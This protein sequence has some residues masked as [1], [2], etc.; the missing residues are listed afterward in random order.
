MT[1]LDEQMRMMP[2]VAYAFSRSH[3]NAVAMHFF[4]NPGYTDWGAAVG[5]ARYG[6]YH[7]S[8]ISDMLEDG[9]ILDAKTGQGYS[10]STTA[11]SG[12]QKVQAGYEAFCR[13]YAGS[14]MIQQMGKPDW[15]AYAVGDMG[16]NAMAAC[17]SQKDGTRI[18]AW[19]KGY[20][21]LVDAGLMTGPDLE[22]AVMDNLA[23]YGHVFGNP[24][25]DPTV[26]KAAA[27]Y[28]AMRHEAGHYHHFNNIF[29]RPVDAEEYQTYM[30][31]AQFYRQLAEE[32]KDSNYAMSKFYGAIADVSEAKASMY[33]RDSQYCHDKAS[34]DQQSGLEAA[35][36]LDCDATEGSAQDAESSD[37]AGDG[38]DASG[39]GAGDGGSD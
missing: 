7:P 12:A 1:T 31:T 9:A 19:N 32:T 33:G 39:D 28:E 21:S 6:T 16:S 34:D 24:D 8:D 27:F 26:V 18:L 15:A 38:S 30:E 14:R 35:L 25:K 5:G 10:K 37:S 4:S 29:D 2:D 17:I 23:R 20:N 13:T 36:E 3:G 22:K 11:L